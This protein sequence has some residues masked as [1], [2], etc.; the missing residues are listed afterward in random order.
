MAF[1]PESRKDDGLFL[2]LSLAANTTYAD[3][4]SVASRFGVL[5][6]A[7]ERGKTRALLN[8]LS[9][10]PPVPSAKVVNLSG[11]NQQKVLFARWLFRSPRVLILDE[12]TRGVDVAAR[13]AIHRLINDLAAEGSAV[14]LI[15][16][17]IEEV[18]G[19]A[20]R[21]LVMRRGSVT[22]EFGADPPMDAVMEAAFGLGGGTIA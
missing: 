20:H 3:L 8:T 6:L 11:G 18:L 13:A 12:P 1:L 9:V 17:E 19:L 2:E 7:L 10:E 5:R 15:S 22:R 4:R 16:S 21:V 14:L